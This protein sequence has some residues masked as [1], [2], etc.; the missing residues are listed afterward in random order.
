MRR[1][2]RA[3]MLFFGATIAVAGCGD[4]ETTSSSGQGGMTS[5]SNA[6]GNAVPPYGAPGGFPGEGGM[7]GDGGDGGAGGGGAGGN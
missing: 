2:K 5:G 7:G 6:G 3:A 1:L 4:G